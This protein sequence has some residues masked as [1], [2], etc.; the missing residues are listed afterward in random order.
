MRRL[1]VYLS[2]I[3]LLA[4]SLAVAWVAADWPHCCRMLGWCTGQGLL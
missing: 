4:V 1:A 2:L 3:A